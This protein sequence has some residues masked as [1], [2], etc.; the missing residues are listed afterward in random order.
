MTDAAL[1]AL[2]GDT[3]GP[4][5][6]G[7]V[8]SHS[9]DLAQMPDKEPFAEVIVGK[10]VPALGGNYCHA[11]SARTLHLTADSE[12]G[13]VHIELGAGAKRPV[14]K[15]RLAEWT[16]DAKRTIQPKGV[17]VLQHWLAARYRRATF[18]DAFNDR[19]GAAQIPGK[20]SDL[21]KRSGHDI[22]CLFFEVD[23]GREE[24]RRAETDVY[25]LRIR[26][27]YTLEKNADAHD[28]ANDL[29]A[30]I[31]D[32]FQRV[33]LD[34]KTQEWTN[35]ELAECDAVSTD[36]LTFEESRHGKKWDADHLSLRPGEK[37]PI[38][39]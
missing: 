24:E 5:A 32:L 23:D 2:F 4:D 21:L 25:L 12:Q 11:K 18:P 38:L 16:P 27:V 15:D 33:F 34:S 8:V 35:V 28:I 36:V 29:V 13:P 17:D 31:I 30:K 19:L 22:V 20:L 37:Q 10:R 9:C 3:L 6:V 14:E 26:A 39:E 7:V 1:R